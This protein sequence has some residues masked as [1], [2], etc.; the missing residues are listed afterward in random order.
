MRKYKTAVL[1]SGNGSNLQA[2]IDAAQAEDYPAH[3]ALV[4]SNRPDAYG[5]K[6]ADAAGIAAKVITHGEFAMREAFDQAVHT[7]L[8]ENG[9]EFVCLA[10]FMRLLSPWFVWQWRNRLVNIHPSLL[11]AF[12]GQRA[13]RDALHYGVKITG[14]TVHYVTAEMD[15][16]PI[17]MQSA[18]PVFPKDTE[19]SLGER[20]HA[21]E[22]LLYPQA[23]KAALETLSATS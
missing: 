14:C 19:E 12:K 18:I 20:M 9:I 4:I 13:L 11:P 10:G 5:L 8:I 17:I 1:I 16:G 23:L 3:I 6:R 21:A 2:L 22:H 7:A 15:S